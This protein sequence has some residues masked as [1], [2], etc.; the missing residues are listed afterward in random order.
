MP[1]E[2]KMWELILNWK[3]CGSVPMEKDPLFTCYE[4]EELKKLP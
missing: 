3:L 4:D 1:D 2:M